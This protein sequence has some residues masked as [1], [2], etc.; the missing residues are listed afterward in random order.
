MSTSWK[1]NSPWGWILVA[2]AIG[3]ML[4]ALHLWSMVSEDPLLLAPVMDARS[5]HDWAVDILSD[6]VGKEVFFQSPAYPY[7][8]ALIYAVTGVSWINVALVQ[9]MAAGVGILL[10]GS[11]GR[12]ADPAGGPW[13][14]VVAAWI[15]ALYKPMIYYDALLL[16]A[17]FT[18][19]TSLILLD[20]TLRA[21]EAPR[22]RAALAWM[23][24]AG[25]T[26]ALVGLFRG[27]FYLAVPL[28][29]GWIP[30][31][32][33]MR[34]GDPNPDWQQATLK[35]PILLMAAFALGFAA[36]IGLVGAR[37]H[38]VSGQWVFSNANSGA[39]L[40]LGN[41]PYSPLGEYTHL[42]FVRP[43]PLYEALDF[44]AE[45]SRRS[46]TPLTDAEAST[47]WRK[48]AV[49]FSLDEPL[50]TARR[51]LHK[52]ARVVESYELG[53]NYGLRFHERAS[54]YLA[55]P[56][57]GWPLVIALAIASLLTLRGRWRDHM[58]VLILAL[59]Y[60]A[61]LL[62]FF[63][64]SRYRV[65]MA[66]FL[67]IMA[68]SYLI[69][70]IRQWRSDR[71]GRLVAGALVA[72]IALAASFV[73]GLP[74]E[75]QGNM[76]WW[77]AS[78]AVLHFEH[79]NIE[80]GKALTAVA[81]AEDDSNPSMLVNLGRVHLGA[82][83]LPAAERLC[84]RA[85]ELEPARPEQRDCLAMTLAELG[86][87]QEAREVLASAFTFGGPP[88]RYI[89][90]AFLEEMNG[91]PAAAADRLRLFL[92]TYGDDPQ[93]HAH[94]ARLLRSTD[95]QAAALHLD[96]AL[97]LAPAEADSLKAIAG[98]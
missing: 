49:R 97:E 91:D 2:A 72:L 66:P 63:V 46:G 65:P 79:G 56:L 96:R 29:L 74:R 33:L 15:L 16:K 20:F 6:P 40:Y 5:Y 28:L 90:A 26:A 1:I 98:P 37:N 23:L 22:R 48:E 86:R 34:R 25:F 17:E 94:L 83:D 32:W 76:A 64:R 67:I 27:N 52:S 42:P 61:T 11:I 19:L 53:D 43:N 4:R 13:V 85:V 45:A 62:I 71:R 12:R 77:N 31:R 58:P 93:I 80:R 95:P 92:K 68:S 47:F 55:L 59:T 24:A 7:I 82:G 44:Q 51:L 50:T 8:V 41:N 89:L 78:L 73:L 88:H 60:A 38:A 3:V 69:V 84:R 57:P 21:L 70:F 9:A 14:G 10:V 54:P 87:A 75:R 39:V 36:L 81:L 18:I 30:A 35:T